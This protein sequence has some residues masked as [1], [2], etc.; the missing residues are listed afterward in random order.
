MSRTVDGLREG[1]S[2][3]SKESRV[4]LVYAIK[5][6]DPIYIYDPQHLL[7]GHEPK[8]KELYLDSDKW[9]EAAQKTQEMK[10]FET[11]YMENLQLAGLISF[12]CMSPSVFYQMWF[13]EHHPDMCAIGPTVRWLEYAVSQLSQNLAMQ[14]VSTVNTSGYVLQEYA[15]HAVRDYIVDR[16]NE[17]MGPDT[18]LR[19]YPILDAV[20]GISRSLHEGAHPRGEIV[21]VEPTG[22]SALNFLAQFPPL[23]RPRLEHFKHVRKLLQSVEGSDRKLVS[24]GERLLGIAAGPMPP[25][26]ISAEFHGRHGFLRL[27][28]EVVCSFSDGNFHSNMHQAKLVEIEEALLESTLDSWTQHSLFKIVSSIV[29][30]AEREKHGCTLIV[31]L[32]NESVPISGQHLEEPVDLR[33]EHLLELAKS[34]A[35]VDG[36]LHIRT[37]LKLHGFACL[38]DGRSVPA[39]DRARGARYN[40]A[41]RFTA[42]HDELIVVVVSTDWPVSI[43]QGGMEITSTCVWKPPVGLDAPSQTLA[44]WMTQ[45]GHETIVPLG[46]PLGPP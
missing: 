23:E 35:K 43:I 45:Q 19:V 28:D 6:E 11:V 26:R 42:E 34:L 36:A 39:E 4:A 27:E 17:M 14:N 5:S 29:H 32:K 22:L 20:L 1:L 46:L 30:N 33:Q 9:R 21:F 31:D 44:A 3:F 24:D 12:G 10:P 18:R 40:S 7:R 8:L 37:D 38:L 13:T 16:R 2:H 41:L 15:T 25:T